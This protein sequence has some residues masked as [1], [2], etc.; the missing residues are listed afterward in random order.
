[1]TRAQTAGPW[2]LVALGTLA[3]GLAAYRFGDWRGPPQRY[4]YLSV[5]P[6]LTANPPGLVVRY[7]VEKFRYCQVWFERVVYDAGGVVRVQFAP[8]SSI[9]EGLGIQEGKARFNLPTL[10][11]GTYTY[12]SIGQFDCPERS[13]TI[14]SP[15][16]SFTIPPW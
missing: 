2:V 3:I 12:R 13:W 1:M 11:P 10:P 7:K 8:G 16:A 15:D 14:V 4:V 9:I 6:D 5:E